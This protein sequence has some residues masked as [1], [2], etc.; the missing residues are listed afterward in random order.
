[1]WSQLHRENPHARPRRRQAA[2]TACSGSTGAAR[3]GSRARATRCPMAEQVF[4]R[5]QP[6]AHG[7]DVDAHAL[8]RGLGVLVAVEVGQQRR[9]Q[10]GAA[11]RSCASSGPIVASRNCRGS[12]GRGSR[13]ASSRAPARSGRRSGPARRCGRAPRAR[14]AASR[15]APGS[16]P[17]ARPAAT[18]RRDARAFSSWRDPGRRPPGAPRARRSRRTGRR[19]RRRC[20]RRARSPSGAMRAEAA[21]RIVGARAVH[22]DQQQ[23]ERPRQVEAVLLGAVGEHGRSS[24]RGET[25]ERSSADA[26]RL[27]DASMRSLRQQHDADDAASCARRC[28]PT[29]R[30]ARRDGTAAP[31]RACRR[32]RSPASRGRSRRRPRRR[33]PSGRLPARRAAR[34]P[35]RRCARRCGA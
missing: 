22:L 33:P 5:R 17:A 24:W 13:T 18:A 30:R 27:R 12:P 20:R 35:A 19:A 21:R 9:R 3:R 34:A 10:L 26:P 28:A 11:L 29:S 16:P 8:R 2:A 32:R 31:C 6:L 14:A 23:R 25:S 1:M 15:R 4:D 7:V